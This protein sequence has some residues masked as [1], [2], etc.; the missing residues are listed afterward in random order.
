MNYIKQYS[1][2]LFVVF[3]SILL[4]VVCT[5]PTKPDF[6]APS[7]EN[8]KQIQTFGNESVGSAFGMYIINPAII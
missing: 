6:T 3:S 7:I 2:V 5:E 4:W 8:G 1:F